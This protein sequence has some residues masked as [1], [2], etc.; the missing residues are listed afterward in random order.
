MGILM[1][2]LGGIGA[3]AGQIADANT[4]LWNDQALAQQ[5][6]DL[7]EQKAKNLADYQYKISHQDDQ[8]AAKYL[9]DP[10]MV[11]SSPEGLITQQQIN[12]K[13]GP[14]TSAVAPIAQAGQLGS[15]TMDTSNGQI[16]VGASSAISPNLKAAMMYA[17]SR[18]NPNAVSPKGAIGPMQT[19]P[20]T[21][22]DPGF[23][24]APAKDNSP[25]ELTRVGNDYAD[26]MVSKYGNQTIAAIAY[27]WGPG[28]TDKWLA[29]G[30]DVS[31]LPAETR[32]YA[33][34]VNAKAAAMDSNSPTTIDAPAAPNM[35]SGAG[36]VLSDGS[37]SGTF[38]GSDMRPQ[39]QYE[40]F[41]DAM[42]KAMADK[43]ISA[44]MELKKVAADRFI[45]IPDGG[46]MDTQT[47]EI[48]QPSMTKFERASAIAQQNNDARDARQQAAFAQRD[49]DAA[50]K[51]ATAAAAN[52]VDP[53]LAKKIANYEVDIQTRNQASRDAHTTAAMTFNPD[54][55]SSYY[56]SIKKVNDDY[57]SSS[58]SSA[59][60]KITSLNRVGQHA[61]LYMQLADAEA[62]GDSRLINSLKASITNAFGA[63]TPLTIKGVGQALAGELNATIVSGPGGEAERKS[64]QDLFSTANSPDQAHDV[65]N[66]AVMPL[67]QGQVKSLEQKYVSVPGGNPDLRLE[68]FKQKLV[69]QARQFFYGDSGDASGTGPSLPANI[70]LTSSSVPVTGIPAGWN[71]TVH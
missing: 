37:A 4:K 44:F 43:N 67:L 41:Q 10:R 71:V 3:A 69:P 23:G 38:A 27:N 1:G 45:P 33:A 49:K 31:K 58:P 57:N 25:A 50:T 48:I 65:I 26:A 35:Q 2:A 61:Q 6:S 21:L 29:A 22:K 66:K 12:A 13:L 28:N 63:S 5:Q 9:S 16:P 52:A 19:M 42:T 56:G 34:T 54:Y 14:D 53:A 20:D 11:Q 30:G 59:G 39:N 46:L 64:F 55:N 8:E 68:Q 17:E 47:H 62:N 40:V 24:V 70:P 15:G 32:K 18:G 36:G 7:A 51:A 60:G